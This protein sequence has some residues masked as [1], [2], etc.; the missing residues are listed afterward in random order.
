MMTNIYTKFK[1]VDLT[2][3]AKSVFISQSH[4]VIYLYIFYITL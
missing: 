1:Y 2:N 4:Y 3:I